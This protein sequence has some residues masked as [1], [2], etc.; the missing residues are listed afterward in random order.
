MCKAEG[1]LGNIQREFYLLQAEEEK[2]EDQL[3]GLTMSIVELQRR[4]NFQP[5][6]VYFNKIRVL[7]R[8]Q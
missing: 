4:L 8:K 2:F 1:C 3:Q 7:D 6:Q 5:Q